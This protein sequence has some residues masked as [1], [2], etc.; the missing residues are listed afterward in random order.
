M[1][2]VLALCWQFLTYNGFPNDHYVHVARARQMLLGALPVRDYVDPGLPLTYAVSASA[3]WMAGDV[4]GAEL[5]VVAL[6]IA[7]GAAATCLCATTLAQST[8]I[9]SAVTLLEILASPRSYSY[10]KIVLY[11][12]GGVVIVGVAR[13]GSRR[14]V[15]SAAVLTALAFLMRHDHGL[16]LGLACATALVLSAS[17]WTV[18]A[19][20]LLQFGVVLA[21]LLLP[22]AVWV[23]YYGGLVP[24]FESAIAF[25]RR[26]AD[27]SVMRDLPRLQIGAGISADNAHAWL[28]YLFYALPVVCA[29][30]ALWRGLS[31]RQRWPGESAA[32]GAIALVALAID[33]G[34]LRN[35]LST[36]LADATVPA[37]FLGAWLLGLAW[38]MRSRWPAATMLVRAAAGVMLIV[39]GVAVW[40]VGDVTNKLD[41]VGV[42]DDWDHVREHAGGIATVLR[43]PEMEAR[44]LPSRVSAGLVPFF[45]YLDRCT[46]P[47]DRLFVSGPYPDVFVLARRGFAGGH[48]AFMQ[49][50][51]V[52]D[53]DQALT[54]ARMRH[55]SVPF[56]LLVLDEQDAFAG[57]FPKILAYIESTY[58]VLTDVPVDGMKGVRV[59]VER[60]R[61]RTGVDAKTGWPCFIQR[62]SSTAASS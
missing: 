60:S 14:W 51:Y 19:R 61:R 24:Y 8:I 52:S 7:V 35:P 45:H 59:L 16:Y 5:L 50:F 18:I 12:I 62:G 25:S 26:E 2:F 42:F 41:E 29:V 36:R 56:V 49:A 40:R 21:V 34:F 33:A 6:G 43:R 53:S 32:I 48:I 9:G 3:R 37:C 58:D 4:A 15:L 22:W 47:T 1:F 13:Q 44:K 39:T 57:S 55:E 38:T 30:L 28:F 46:A 11:A 23:Q 10:P 20:R 54:L 31:R 17:D 27:I